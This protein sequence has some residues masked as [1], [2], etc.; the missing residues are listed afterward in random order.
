MEDLKIR[1]YGDPVLREKARPVERV[2][3]GVRR[4]LAAMAEAMYAA[5]GVGLAAPQVGVLQR[6]VVIDVGDGLLELVNPEIVASAGQVEGV[7][8]CL[9]LPGLIGDVVRSESVTVRA[10]DGRGRPFEISGQGL[11]ARA[12]Q[13]EIDHLDGVL[14]IDKA[15]N[16]RPAKSG[17][18][19]EG[20]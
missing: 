19:G 15:K 16:L 1:L 20:R 12:L 2:D 3:A 7:E 4:F 9:S 17:E 18:E 8:G 13:H 5:E 14:F 11:L 6:L 10:L